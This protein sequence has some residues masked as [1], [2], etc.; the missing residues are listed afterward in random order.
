MLQDWSYTHSITR[1]IDFVG[2]SN[3]YEI[4][5]RWLKYFPME[6]ILVLDGD[7]LISDPIQEIKRTEAFLGLRHYLNDSWFEF[8]KEKNFYCIKD[9]IHGT[10]RCLGESK[11]RK[12]PEIDE[13]TRQRLEQY[14]K[15]YNEKLFK[16]IG[17]RFN[18]WSFIPEDRL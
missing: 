3:Y 18:W 16:L 11:G 1:H 6:Q 12:H 5:Q 14:Y 10:P 17:R 13:H 7:L 8:V 15:P 2:R 4:L 9:G